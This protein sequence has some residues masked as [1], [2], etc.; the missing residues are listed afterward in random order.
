MTIDSH[1][2]LH[3]ECCEA[4]VLLGCLARSVEQRSCV[5]G[6]TPVTVLS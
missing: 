1:Q 5:G 2:R 6:K 3:Y 4:Q